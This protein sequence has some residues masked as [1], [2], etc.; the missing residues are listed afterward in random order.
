MGNRY[1]TNPRIGFAIAKKQVAKA[2][3]RNRLK[4]L[5]RESFRRQQQKLPPKDMVILVRKE[6]LKLDN[7]ALQAVL[8]KQWTRIE[9]HAKNSDT[10]N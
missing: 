10:A 4:R 2:V 5:V 3:D 9:S 1:G 6:I 7:A 8:E